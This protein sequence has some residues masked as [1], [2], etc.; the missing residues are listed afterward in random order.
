MDVKNRVHSIENSNSISDIVARIFEYIV[1]ILAKDVGSELKRRPF[2]QLI[3]HKF[4]DPIVF[5]MHCC[6]DENFGFSLFKNFVQ[7]CQEL[8]LVLGEVEL[9]WD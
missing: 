1:Q 4:A 3:L 8:M 7:R 9:E 5:V 6:S 2:F